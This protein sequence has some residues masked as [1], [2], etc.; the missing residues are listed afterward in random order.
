VCVRACVCVYVC[1]CVRVLYIHACMSWGMSLFSFF[2]SAVRE[3]PRQGHV[4]DRHVLACVSQAVGILSRQLGEHR[5]H[6]PQK[7]ES[8]SLQP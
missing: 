7:D 5:K 3:Y 6:L 4:K 2:G 1:V 8:W